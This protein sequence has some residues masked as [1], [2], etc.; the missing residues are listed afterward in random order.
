MK[1]AEDGRSVTFNVQKKSG[2]NFASCG[3][4]DYRA[5]SVEGDAGYKCVHKL[6]VVE[7]GAAKK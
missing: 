3:C 6:A 5:H 2:D 1:T 4:P 7:H